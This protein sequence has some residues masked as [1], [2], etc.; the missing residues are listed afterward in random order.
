LKKIILGLIITLFF[1]SGTIFAQEISFGQPAVQTVKII[2]N[3]DG[4]AHVTHIVEPS[5]S[6]QQLTVI[7]NDFANLQ[8]TDEGGSPIEY[9]ETSGTKIGFLIFPIKEKVYV[10]YDLE[11]AVSEKNG[12]LTWDYWYL[13]T[14]AFYLPKQVDL[15][16]VN[17]NPIALNESDGVR[18]HGC[19]AILEY[20]LVQKETIEQVQ[21][22]ESKFDVKIIADME[23]SSF[24]FNQPN[25]EISF[26]VDDKNKYVTLIIPLEL[27]GKPYDVF[28]NGKIIPYSPGYFDEERI[29]LGIKPNETGTVEI[30]GTTVIPEFP[31]AAV[32][33]LA[34]AMIFATRY[35]NRLNLH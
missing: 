12:V 30:V 24:E 13:A 26:I 31:I 33:V 2:I 22:E 10:D 9:A 18:C 11:G 4:S 3:E 8:I 6:S 17:G 28:L 15:I 27:L 21:W 20:K 16:F 1:S 14:T 29:L 32:L 5:S 35:G 19:Q 25:K 34:T 7:R 23:I